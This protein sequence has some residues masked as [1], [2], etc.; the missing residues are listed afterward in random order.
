MSNPRRTSGFTYSETQDLQAIKSMEET[1]FFS[2]H[3]QIPGNLDPVPAA[4]I[5]NAPQDPKSENA[6]ST[7]ASI[8]SLSKSD[9]SSSSEEED[10]SSTSDCL[11]ENVPRDPLDEQAALLVNFLL[12]KYQMKESITKAD[13]LNVMGKYRSQFSEVILKATERM[14]IVFGLDLKEVDPICHNYVIQIKLGLT[15]DGM[16]DGEE[17][18]PKTGVLILVLGVIFMKGNRATEEEVWEVLN[19]TGMYS[20]QKHFIFGNLKSLITEV[21]VREKYLEYQKVPNSDPIQYEFLWGPRAYTETTKMKILEFLAKV[22]GTD[23]SSF[24][25]QYE[26]ALKEEEERAQA[27]ANLSTTIVAKE[28]S[29]ATFGSSSHP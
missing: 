5:S 27:A 28:S 12:Q 11:D 19:V 8:T 14:E 13:M 15:Y 29:S 7:T 3:P 20:G 22:H 2:T 9:D 4:E 16:L 1:L 25:S 17:S 6:T 26:E 21:F 24:P 18:M 10:S 23:P